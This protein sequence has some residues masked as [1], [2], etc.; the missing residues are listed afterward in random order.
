MTLGADVVGLTQVEAERRAALLS[1]VRYDIAVDYTDL[2]TGPAVRCVSTVTF[3][4]AEPGAETFVDCAARM[5]TGTLNG[6]P[7]PPAAGGRIRLPALAAQNTLRVETV[8][9]DTTGGTGVHKAVDPVDG[10]VYVW[11]ARSALSRSQCRT[12]WG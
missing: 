9:T 3:S 5:V 2:P 4:C 10:E 7:L 8:Q 11:T 12:S 1:V 6:H